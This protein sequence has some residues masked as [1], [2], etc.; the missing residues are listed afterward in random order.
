[1]HIL[2]EFC[3]SISFN[4]NSDILK[5]N[6]SKSRLTVISSQLKVRRMR[7]FSSNSCEYYSNFERLYSLKVKYFSMYNSCKVNTQTWKMRVFRFI[8]VMKNCLADWDLLIRT[9]L[10]CVLCYIEWISSSSSKHII[11]WF[12]FNNF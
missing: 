12:F 5:K 10:N 3:C 8:C 2:K 7:D 4:R 6:F 11:Q 1:M 9:A